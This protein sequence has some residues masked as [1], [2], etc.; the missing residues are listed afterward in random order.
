MK[1]VSSVKTIV[2]TDNGKVVPIEMQ[3]KGKS[4][5]VMTSIY[6]IHVKTEVMVEIVDDRLIM[7]DFVILNSMTNAENNYRNF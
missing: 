2:Q 3:E 1:N 7:N 6:W 4:V 5:C